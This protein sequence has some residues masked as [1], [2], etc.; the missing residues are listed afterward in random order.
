MKDFKHRQMLFDFH[1]SGDIENV[2]AQFDEE[3]FG[4][5]L[6]EVGVEKITI[7][8]KCHHSWCYYCLLY[9]SDA[10]DD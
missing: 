3:S 10:A 2:G 8:S 6:E 9:T 7:F 4:R 5:H 1:T